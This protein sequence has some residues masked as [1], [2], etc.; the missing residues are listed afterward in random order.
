[1]RLFVGRHFPGW[2][3]TRKRV[4]PGRERTER[5]KKS[6]LWSRTL[7]PLMVNNRG[8]SLQKNEETSYRVTVGEKRTR[9]KESRVLVIVSYVASRHPLYT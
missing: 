2:F 1:M 3:P 6:I 8:Q 7:R 9:R 4:D 5:R